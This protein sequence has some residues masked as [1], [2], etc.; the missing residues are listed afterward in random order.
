M[1]ENISNL[2]NNIRNKNENPKLDNQDEVQI[3]Y[4]DGMVDIITY[5][6]DDKYIDKSNDILK[7]N[8]DHNDVN[9]YSN[10][11]KYAS[12]DKHHNTLDNAIFSVKKKRNL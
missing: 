12:E 2:I 10:N 7:V 9:P 11:N 5:N 3:S 1:N 4:P 8:S 6:D